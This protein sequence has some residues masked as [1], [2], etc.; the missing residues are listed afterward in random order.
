[1]PTI[2]EFWR[3]KSDIYRR[4]INREDVILWESAWA[5]A[6]QR[7]CSGVSLADSLELGEEE[8][9]RAVARSGLPTPSRVVRYKEPQ[10][11]II[12]G[13]LDALPPEPPVRE[14][15]RVLRREPVGTSHE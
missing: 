1:M 4:F 13:A 14:L 2:L 5:V 9:V 7:C 12:N 11:Y 8:L 15:W 6:L 3:S 10:E